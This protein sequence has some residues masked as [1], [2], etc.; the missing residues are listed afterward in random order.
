VTNIDSYRS[1]VKPTLINEAAFAMPLT[2]TTKDDHDKA[3]QLI[4]TARTLKAEAT[5]IYN[6][7]LAP[8]NE[9][10]NVILKWKRDDLGQ[11][12][13]VIRHLSELLERY[14]LDVQQAQERAAM[15]ALR[16]AERKAVAERNDEVSVMIDLAESDSTDHETSSALLQKAEELK[17]SPAPIVHA[18]SED[19][20]PQ[21]RLK[22]LGLKRTTKQKAEVVD[23]KEL[24]R[25]IADGFVSIE[26][27]RPNAAYLNRRATKLRDEFPN[28]TPGCKLVDASHFGRVSKGVS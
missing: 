27:V 4:I 24:C 3:A 12:D 26:A 1:I 10:R 13:S 22:A 21:E 16:E 11:L 7:M 17:A 18:F 28:K 19:Q 8:L 2:L 14:V 5:E 9:R 6:E 15:N 25:A 20:S 23:I